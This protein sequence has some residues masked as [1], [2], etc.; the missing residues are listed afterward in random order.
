MLLIQLNHMRVTSVTSHTYWN[1][2]YSTSVII[3]KSTISI[4]SAFHF[5]KKKTQMFAVFHITI[6]SNKKGRWYLLL[7]QIYWKVLREHHSVVFYFTFIFFPKI[8]FSLSFETDYW[9]L[10]RKCIMAILLGKFI[11]SSRFTYF[12]INFSICEKYMKDTCP[13]VVIFTETRR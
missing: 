8:H 6:K 13:E 4:F 7:Y 11:F 2:K 12:L 1:I 5:S 9:W 3:I 10:L